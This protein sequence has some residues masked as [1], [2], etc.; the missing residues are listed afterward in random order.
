M[1]VLPVVLALALPAAAAASEVP[2]VSVRETAKGT[3]VVLAD[4][5]VGVPADVARDVLTDYAAL[6]RI[7]PDIKTSRII[8]RTPTGALVEQEAVST[9]AFFSK[10]VHLLLRI[11][12]GSDRIQFHDTCGRSFAT[13]EGLWTILPTATGVRLMYQ[14]TAAPTFDVPLFVI[15]KVLTGD[16]RE[17]AE[18]LSAEMS[19]RAQV[20]RTSGR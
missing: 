3:Y 17:M 20:G 18:R 14:L 7:I 15:R 12:E 6:P 4:F 11:E 19:A 9:F 2:R 10:R 16:A 1:R 5:E 13:Y 8:E